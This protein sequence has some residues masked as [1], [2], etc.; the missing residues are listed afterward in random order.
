[1]QRV[2]VYHVGQDHVG[3]AAAMCGETI[4]TMCWQCS[5]FQVDVMA[6]D[7]NKAAYRALQRTLDVQLMNAACYSSG[8]TG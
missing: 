3:R 2:C 8:L 1:M 5:Y 6:G 4:A 7:G